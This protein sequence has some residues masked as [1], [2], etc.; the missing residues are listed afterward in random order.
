MLL[1][2]AHCSMNAS[3]TS[4]YFSW[5]P[6]F[7]EEW[8]SAGPRAYSIPENNPIFTVRENSNKS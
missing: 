5:T 4:E 6:S 8:V 2:N 7:F 3:Q 1:R